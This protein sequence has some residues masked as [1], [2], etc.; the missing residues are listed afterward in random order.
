MVLTDGE[1]YCKTVY[2]ADGT[3]ADGWHEITEAE[4]E[5]IEKAMM[6]ETMME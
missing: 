1:T 4:H 6:A 3:T 5:E 2:L